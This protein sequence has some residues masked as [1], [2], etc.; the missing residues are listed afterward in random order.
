VTT[1]DPISVEPTILHVDMDAF[2]AAV[3]LVRHPELR[4]RPVV[5]GGSGPRG[6]VAAASYE[7]RAHGVHSAMAGVTARRLCPHAVFLPGDHAHYSEVSTR[8]MAVFA[9]YTP[10]VEP[11]SLDE[12]FLDVSGARRLIGSAEQIAHQIRAEIRDTEKLT[13]SVGVARVKFLAKLAS[14]AAKPKASPTG[15]RFGPGVVIVDPSRE[16]EFLH[17]MPVRALWGVGPATLVKLERLG[18]ATVGHLAET[19]LPTLIAALGKASGT[20]LHALANVVDPRGVVP[21]QPMKSVSHEETFPRDL[22]D[23]ATVRVELARLADAVASRL[24]ASGTVGRTIGV[25]VR[26]GDFRTVSRSSSVTEPTD[27]THEITRVARS[28]LD[29]IDLTP[30]VRLLGVSVTQLGAGSVRQLSLDDLLVE[31]PGPGGGGDRGQQSRVEAAVDEVRARFGARAVGPANLIG[32]NGLRVARR[33]AQQWGPVAGPSSTS[34]ADH[35][36]PDSSDDPNARHR[37]DGW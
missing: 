15:P 11:I 20:H 33:G 25:K 34:D 23:A 4:G 30:G 28:L 6:V 2:F 24:R 29:G 31:A 17:P 18:I 8:V 22:T 13:C 35:D 7:A 14:E 12:A 3:E 1:V 36:H 9:R 10:L 16:T 21:G 32:P 19:P 5:V 37:H 27:T 26:Y